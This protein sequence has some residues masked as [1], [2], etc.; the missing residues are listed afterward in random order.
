M[1]TAS[2]QSTM[3][4]R[5][6]MSSTNTQRISQTDAQPQSEAAA[7]WRAPEMIP[8][9]CY[10]DARAAVEWLRQA[11]GFEVHAVHEEGGTVQHA[12][13]RWGSGMVM[14]GSVADEAYAGRRSRDGVYVIVEDVDAHCSRARAA[15]AEIVLEPTDQPYGSRDYQ[16]RDREGHLW[17]FGTYRPASS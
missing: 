2:K 8:T 1:L 9:L 10:H 17:S 13:L 14:L 12:E 15:G 11:F 16:A 3:T 6:Q 4:E 7:G 5:F